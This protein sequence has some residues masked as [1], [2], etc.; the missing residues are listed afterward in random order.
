MVPPLVPPSTSRPRSRDRSSVIDQVDRNGQ[1][2]VSCETRTGL[3]LNIDF[4]RAEGPQERHDS[5]EK[6]FAGTSAFGAA[7]S[8]AAAS[9]RFRRAC[10]QARRR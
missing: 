1:H 6:A 3:D 4:W 2:S 7:I 5:G 9:R 10:M 8:R